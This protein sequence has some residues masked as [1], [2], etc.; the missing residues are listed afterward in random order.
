[1]KILQINA[2]YG[3]GS[4]GKIVRDISQKLLQ[5]GHES[6]VMWATGCREDDSGVKLVRIGSTLDHKVH[7][8]LRRL[9]GGQAMH[10]KL[11]TKKACQKILEIAPDVVHL[12]NLHSNYIHLPTL[13]AFL[14]EQEIPTLLTLHDCWFFTGCCPHYKNENNCQKWLA[15][16]IDCPAVPS[17]WRKNIQKR[18][19]RR[20][21]LFGEMQHLAVNGVSQWTT[22]AA[23]Q[24]I[25]KT[26]AHTRCIYNWVDTQ[27]FRPREDISAIRGKYGV[28]ENRKLILGVSQAWGRDKGLD[29]F[30]MLAD[31]LSDRAQVVLVGADKGVP[32]RDNLQ[33]IGYT[34]N[35][36]EMIALYSAADVL[37]NAS[38]A[39][40]FGLVTAEAMACGTPVVAYD[41]SG[42]SELVAPGCGTLVLDGDQDALAAA[43]ET[44]LDTGKGVYA[45]ACRD[46][47][48]KNFE[49][50]KQL[51]AYLCFYQEIISA[52]D[53]HRGEES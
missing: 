9:D 11:A 30:L 24:S 29:S 34:A 31:K 45:K 3:M 10:S 6:H 25:L 17:V 16:C 52:H 14:A 39:E 42:S 41:N 36:E 50:N 1:M 21:A 43:V 40:T 23:K 15:G 27:L 49:K 35:I 46:H 48:L 38:P 19:A 2:V 20:Q 5:Q 8:L 32:Q 13:L 37:V 18:F 44:V 22:E 4:T 28:P 7:A 26:A 33:C 51:E 12:H 53:L 47:V